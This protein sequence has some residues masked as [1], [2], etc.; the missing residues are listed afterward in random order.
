MAD[1]PIPPPEGDESDLSKLSEQ[2]RS[3]L[4]AGL[5][6]ARTEPLVS[7]GSF[8]QYVEK[9]LREK[10]LIVQASREIHTDSA[11]QALMAEL[12]KR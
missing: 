3:D 6:S 11:M 2:A 8:F 12:A 7:C 9:R 10:R 4:L 1:R 5:E